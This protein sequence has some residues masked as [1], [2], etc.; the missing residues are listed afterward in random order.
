MRKQ[1]QMF[2]YLWRQMTI[3]R[4]ARAQP[5]AKRGA[6]SGEKEREASASKQAEKLSVPGGDGMRLPERRA[7]PPITPAQIPPS[8]RRTH[9]FLRH[10]ARVCVHVLFQLVPFGRL[11]DESEPE[12]P[13]VPERPEV[14]GQSGSS[15]MESPFTSGSSSSLCSGSGSSSGCCWV[16]E[17]RS[18]WDWNWPRGT[19]V[20]G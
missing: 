11:A 1:R 17:W 12:R 4:S 19:S 7:T 10:S 6:A 14:A 16:W 2:Q 3:L 8:P 13:D 5:R 20:G 9:Q 18:E 15:R